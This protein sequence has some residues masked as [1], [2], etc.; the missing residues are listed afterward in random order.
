L[1]GQ[2]RRPHGTCCKRASHTAPSDPRARNEKPPPA[3][4]GRER[5]VAARLT[6]RSSGTSKMACTA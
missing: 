2:P 5:V 6:Q 4:R 3:G 1:G